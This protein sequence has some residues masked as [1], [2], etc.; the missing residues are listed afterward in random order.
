MMNDG[1]KE[2]NLN[3]KIEVKDITEIIEENLK[4]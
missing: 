2:K 1:L 3:S 4:E